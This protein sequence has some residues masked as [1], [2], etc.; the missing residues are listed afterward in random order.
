MKGKMLLERVWA[1]CD[2]L[3]LA[4]VF[5]LLGLVWHASN[6]ANAALAGS[7][8]GTGRSGTFVRRPASAARL[9]DARRVSAGHTRVN[10]IAR[11]MVAS[12]WEQVPPCPAMD[13]REDGK[14]YEILFSLPE[15][16]AR[17]DVQV[18][19]SGNVLTLVMKAGDRGKMYMQRVRI[20][21]GVERADN[22]RSVISNNVLR[23]RI[24]PPAG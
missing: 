11:S 20:P 17:E 24:Q 2:S 1:G 15:G 23:V 6:R 3:L 5:V 10:S 22:V 16:V 21:C 19:A 4:A 8:G 7:A 18:T 12:E 13:M 9:V 14:T